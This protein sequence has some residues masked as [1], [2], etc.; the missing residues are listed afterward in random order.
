MRTVF[1]ANYHHQTRCESGS[2]NGPRPV[3]CAC[4]Q[5]AVA[6]PMSDDAPGQTRLQT[7]RYVRHGVRVG[8]L[9]LAFPNMFGMIAPPTTYRAPAHV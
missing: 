6:R 4:T 1:N 3:R 5:Y 8:G 9:A 7:F 2:Q